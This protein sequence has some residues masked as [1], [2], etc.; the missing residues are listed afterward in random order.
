MTLVKDKLFKVG[1]STCGKKICEELFRAYNNAGITDMEI[2]NGNQTYN[3]MDYK[4]L[5]TWAKQYGVQLWSYHLPFEPREKIC[6][7][8][9]ECS[10]ATLE[11][12]S[13]IIKKASDIGIDKFVI[14]PSS[15]PIEEHE[16]GEQIECAKEN[17]AKLAEV[18]NQCG[19]VLAVENMARTCLGRTSDELLDIVSVHSALRV[20]F[21]TNHLFGENMHTFIRKVGDK[22]ITIHVSDRDSINER[23]W[24]P[25]EGELDWQVIYQSLKEVGYS[26]PWLYEIGLTPPATIERRTLELCDFV[27]NANAI[28]IGSVPAPIGKKKANLGMWGVIEDET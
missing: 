27:N 1:V 12:F 25:G 6:T 19:A 9:R 24:L 7:S 23:H 20:C 10:A 18:A 13:D 22:I 4:L 11:L 21:D 15:E 3:N 8:K 5:Y 14:H 28:F 2:E 26:G 16:R 17:L